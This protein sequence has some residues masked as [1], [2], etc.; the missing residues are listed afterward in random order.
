MSTTST[1]IDT[2]RPAIGFGRLVRVELRKMTDTRA[3]R[4]LVIIT[5]GLV[6]L[7]AGI[8]LL[9]AALDDGFGATASDFAGVLQFVSL[10][11]LPVFA[12]MI[13]TSEW[14]QRTH[15]TTFTLEPR[16]SRVVLAKAA[17]TAIFS[18]ITLVIAII[19]GAAS[20]AATSL[21]DH[22]PVWNFG[23][24][25]LLWS[26]L[27]QFL[28]IFSAFALGLA[29]LNTASAIALF[30]VAAIMLRFIVYPIMIGIF[31]WFTDLVPFLDMFFAIAVAQTGEDINE[32]QAVGDIARYLPVVVSATI[33]LVIPTLL[34]WLRATRSEI[35]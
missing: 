14:T 9:V 1:M 24:T 20:N 28:L 15:L 8:M 2:T 19:A 26:L 33:W 12:V 25:D 5:L 16:R 18:L 29:I 30:Y 35:K 27:L 32:G 17:A 10:L 7:A 34:G 31:S 21:F 6:L 22:E 13:T 11:I 3:G 23:L 4:A